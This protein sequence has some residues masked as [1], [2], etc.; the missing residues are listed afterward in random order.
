MSRSPGPSPIE[1]TT[2]GAHARVAL[3]GDFDMRATFS[4]E[5]V[6][7]RLLE[8][9]DVRRVTIDLSSLSFID[10]TGFGVLMR[11]HSEATSRG[12]E[13]ALVPGPPEVQRV[14][15]TAGLLDA[16]PFTGRS[17]DENPAAS[18]RDA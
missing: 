16:L 17:D 5:P 9:P 12:I 10:S 6:L 13:L 4:V 11:M 8:D 14:F 18:G 1:V 15:E 3:M 2:D 7:E